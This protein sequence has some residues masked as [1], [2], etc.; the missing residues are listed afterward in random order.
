ML[1]L[2]ATKSCHNLQVMAVVVAGKYLSA[3]QAK[4]REAKAAKNREARCFLWDLQNDL[5]RKEKFVPL[6]VLLLC[7]SSRRGVQTNTRTTCQPC[8]PARLA[9]AA[10]VMLAAPG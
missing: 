3:K 9:V 10:V 2:E 4:R 1:W 5:V 7:L 6:E 8:L